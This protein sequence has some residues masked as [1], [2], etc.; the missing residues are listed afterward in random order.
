MRI[1]IWE[2]IKRINSIL[3]I[4]GTLG[5]L[6]FLYGIFKPLSITIS[7]WFVIP[8]AVMGFFLGYFLKGRIA[9]PAKLSRKTKAATE[10]EIE[11]FS[12]GLLNVEP[13]FEKF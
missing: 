9:L 8:V 1:G 7:I 11:V 6:S 5:I 4:L 10:K 12:D 13:I 3:G 2:I